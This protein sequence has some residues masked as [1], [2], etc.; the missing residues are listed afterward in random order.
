MVNRKIVTLAAFVVALAA[1][2]TSGAE[3]RLPVAP[4]LERLRT[5][6]AAEWRTMAEDLR[7]SEF[8][9]TI[10]ETERSRHESTTRKK[11]VN[12]RLAGECFLFTETIVA[13]DQVSVYGRN[14]RYE[15][16]LARTGESPWT[17]S[18]QSG[19][20]NQETPVG[21]AHAYLGGML[22]L[23]WRL[24]ATPLGTLLQHPRFSILK[25]WQQDDGRVR[26]DFTVS[27]VSG[28]DD[29]LQ[30]LSRGMVLLDPN[31]RWAVVRYRAQ[32]GPTMS[33]SVDLEYADT[34]PPELRRVRFE[35]RTG[36]DR[37]SEFIIDAAK[38]DWSPGVEADFT[39]SA[40]GLPE[41]RDPAIRRRWLRLV[42]AGIIFVLLGLILW[43]R[44]HLG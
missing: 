17:V 31:R 5:E 41:Y 13:T 15:F 23:P 14:D 40:F 37:A 16:A 10:V 39:L 2:G 44:G 38:Y 12:G 26:M 24:S 33:S 18:W 4:L 30:G 1:G 8:D 22:Q 19:Q 28:S 6:A 42:N 20:P 9:Y 32:Y 21:S 25:A 36:P 11:R 27:P 3:A 35:L 43:R 29:E 7:D 34:G